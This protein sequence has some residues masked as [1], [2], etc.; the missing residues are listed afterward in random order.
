M[1][2][3]PGGCFAAVRPGVVRRPG[4]HVGLHPRK[5]SIR[6]GADADLTIVDLDKRDVIDAAR[7][8]GKNNHNPFEGQRTTGEAVP[9]SSA[10]RS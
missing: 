4:A 8:H 1:A 2:C 3:T 5:G 6:V 10:D 9:R 7:L